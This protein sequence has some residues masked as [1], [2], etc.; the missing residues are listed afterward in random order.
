M[1]RR[2][3]RRKPRQAASRVSPTTSLPVTTRARPPA[4]TAPLPYDAAEGAAR[5]LVAAAALDDGGARLGEL[6][7][8]TALDWRLSGTTMA[9]LANAVRS[10]AN[11][12]AE[13][14]AE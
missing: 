14:A 8:Q 11:E 7:G 2:S 6:A 5:Q 12:L 4:A 3:H 10:L 1:G 9:T 13:R